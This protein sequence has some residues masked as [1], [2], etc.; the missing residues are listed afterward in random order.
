MGTYIGKGV[1]E[2]AIVWEGPLGA[3]Y[4]SLGGIFLYNKN[5]NRSQVANIMVNFTH[6]KRENRFSSLKS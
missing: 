6:K 1:N 2:G 4:W 3:L 5:G